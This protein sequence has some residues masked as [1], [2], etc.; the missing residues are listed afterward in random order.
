MKLNNMYEEEVLK[1]Q[2]D[3]GTLGEIREAEKKLR[4]MQH[5]Y[6]KKKSAKWIYAIFFAG[7]FGLLGDLMIPIA[8]KFQSST[9]DRKGIEKLVQR[10]FQNVNVSQAL[11]NDLVITSY[12]YNY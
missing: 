9:Y 1:K 4:D 5:S 3:D 11:S 10:Y 12:E 6:Y 7:L 8:A 2:V